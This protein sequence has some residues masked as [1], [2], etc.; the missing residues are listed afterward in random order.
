MSES[1]KLAIKCI[2]DEFDNDFD[3]S[4]GRN[5][6]DDFVPYRS[7]SIQRLNLFIRISISTIF[8][9]LDR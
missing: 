1:E 8:H 9:C 4:D 7:R 2:H 5:D 6:D 3:G